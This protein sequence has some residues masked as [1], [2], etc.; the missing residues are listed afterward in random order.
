MDYLDNYYVNHLSSNELEL[1]TQKLVEAFELEDCYNLYLEDNINN[2]KRGNIFLGARLIKSNSLIGGICLERKPL[3]KNEIYIENLFVDNRYR[4]QGV[5][6]SLMNYVVDNKKDLFGRHKIELYLFCEQQ[7]ES[8]YK[9][10][11]FNVYD[12]YQGDSQKVLRMSRKI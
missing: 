5:A 1:Y 4:N 12:Y 7:L 8:F 6:S 11:K 2:L 3:Y 10:L 9:K